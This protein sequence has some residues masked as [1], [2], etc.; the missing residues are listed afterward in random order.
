MELLLAGRTNRQI[1]SALSID[2]HTVLRDT[3]AIYRA[4]GVR[5]FG[6]QSRR[7]L[8]EKVGRGVA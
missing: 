4:H 1:M 6:K 8:A 7:R 3:G 2:E 5:G